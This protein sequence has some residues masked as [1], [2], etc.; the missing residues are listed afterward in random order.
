MEVKLDEEITTWSK[1]EITIST[2]GRNYLNKLFEVMT[3]EDVDDVRKI[4]IEKDRKELHL[5]YIRVGLGYR[6]DKENAR[7][8]VKA[9]EQIFVN[10]PRR[11]EIIE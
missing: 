7:A 6:S 1:G 11:S 3:A 8:Q 2:S 4:Y 5:L 9:G 10:Y